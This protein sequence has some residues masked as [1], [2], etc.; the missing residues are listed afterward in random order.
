M[1]QGVSQEYRCGKP[2]KIRNEA[3]YQGMPRILDI[4]APEIYRQHVEGCFC[5]ALQYGCQFSLK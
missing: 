3:A 2:C 5:G 1:E 4:Y